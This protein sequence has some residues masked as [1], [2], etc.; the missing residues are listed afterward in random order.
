M[1]I[2]CGEDRKGSGSSLF[3]SSRFT[4]LFLRG[5][6][7]KTK[8]HILSLPPTLPCPQGE[9]AKSVQQKHQTEIELLFQS[10]LAVI[11][12]KSDMLYIELQHHKVTPYPSFFQPSILQRMTHSEVCGDVTPNYPPPC[13][14]HKFDIQLIDLI[15]SK[16]V[17]LTIHK[18]LLLVETDGLI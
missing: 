8:Q 4:L 15:Q 14:D 11:F 1:W 12:R 16:G 9:S 2:V 6:E 3:F 5:K 13:S 18:N 7:W 10:E 17:T